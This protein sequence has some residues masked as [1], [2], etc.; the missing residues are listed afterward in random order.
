MYDHIDTACSS[1][2][3]AIHSWLLEREHTAVGGGGGGGAGHSLK[4]RPLADW[5]NHD[6]VRLKKLFVRITGLASSQWPFKAP[7]DFSIFWAA[8]RIPLPCRSAIIS[9]VSWHSKIGQER[10]GWGWW[11][12]CPHCLLPAVRRGCGAAAVV[13]LGGGAAVAQDEEGMASVSLLELW[14]N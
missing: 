14:G 8:E 7:L 2:G 1:Y 12:C 4:R 10:V 6:G 9:N 13:S 5:V 3:S 11:D